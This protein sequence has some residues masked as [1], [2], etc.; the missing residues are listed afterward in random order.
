MPDVRR[1]SR[2][3]NDHA[4][5]EI[6]A[7][8]AATR[9]VHTR[10][11]RTVG[12]GDD[13]HVLRVRRPS[14]RAVRRA[15]TG[16]RAPDSWRGRVLAACLGGAPRGRVASHRSAAR[17][18][19]TFR[20]R[21]TDVIEISCR[22]RAGAPKLRTR[23]A[24]DQDSSTDDDIETIEGYPRPRSNRR[25]WDSPRSCPTPSSR[26]QSTSPLR[27]DDVTRERSHMSQRR[28]S[29]GATDRCARAMVASTVRTAGV[30]GER[31][32]DEAQAVAPSS[33]LP[34]PV[35]QY[36]VRHD[37]RFVA[38]VDAAYP[39]QRIAIEYDSYE[40]HLG[41]VAIVP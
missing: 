36:E 21:R 14:A 24:R 8:A 35:F 20:R 33:R 17:V 18:L 2:M 5:G 28:A 31:D 34:M 27:N 3:S 4:T 30:S 13:Q 6:A 38:R 10:T 37:G 25:C 26:W 9:R 7:T 19:G 11:A 39:E 41:T 12:L 29:K 23:R 16:S 32:G 40:Y 15:S 1:L 22:R